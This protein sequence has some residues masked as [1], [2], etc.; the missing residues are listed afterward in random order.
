MIPF[1]ENY[2]MDTLP[3]S[4][5]GE[6]DRALEVGWTGG[7]ARC[8]LMSAGAKSPATWYPYLG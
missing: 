5:F 4:V 2:Q 3:P 6:L 7:I 8:I 1:G